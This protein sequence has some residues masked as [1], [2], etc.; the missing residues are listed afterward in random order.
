M[1]G[2]ILLS[3]ASASRAQFA[4]D[5]FEPAPLPSDGL[6]LPGAQ[7]LP[8]RQWVLSTVTEYARVPLEYRLGAPANLTQRVV[9]DQLVVH[10]G[11][12][13]AV[14]RRVSLFASLP[15]HTWM[16]GERLLIASAA[17]EGAG[18][19][20]LRV[21]ARASLFENARWSV[22]AEL[23]ARAPTAELARPDQRYS[24]DRW[25][26]YDGHATGE[27][28]LGLVDLRARLGVRLREQVQQGDLTASSAFSI[29]AGARVRITTRWAALAE[30]TTST[31]LA[32]PAS[33]RRPAAELLLG[34]KYTLAQLWFALG[35]GPG[36]SNGYGTPQYRVVALLGYHSSSSHAAPSPQPAPSTVAPAPAP[37]DDSVIARE[38]ADEDGDGVPNALDA[39]P[40]E[41][42]GDHATLASTGCPQRGEE[43][44]VV[45]ECGTQLDAT[46]R[47]P[48]LQS[49]DDDAALEAA[50]GAM[51]AFGRVEYAVGKGS[52]LSSSI[53]TLLAVR[54]ILEHN[55][56]IR[57]TRVEGHSD[58]TGNPEYN[59]HLA[60][61]RARAV[62]RWLVER[63]I[64]PE[65]LEVFVCGERYPR[66][67][68]P[69]R[70]G[71]QANRRVEFHVVDPPSTP[72]GHD[73][74]VQV[75]LHD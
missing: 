6:A 10:V 67:A 2:I 40:H 62:A 4:L 1:L 27:L 11:G 7:V 75:P 25:G 64:A 44:P 20:D 35:A 49:P 26:S 28:R 71:L 30:L 55:S 3:C 29:A 56:Q 63:G 38:D 31:P 54:S 24:G 41:A 33:A 37:R 39:C 50:G 51:V 45:A 17:P 52:A 72:H 14:H 65:R 73:E 47:C 53:P 66:A 5:Q 46:G 15:V 69:E 32:A 58:D 36:L 21:G 43:A 42:A 18:I 48:G 34:G 22:A 70:T 13:I 19:G 61:R 16:R 59:F 9:S 68:D 74:C 60:R 8:S 57:R 23:I 12:A